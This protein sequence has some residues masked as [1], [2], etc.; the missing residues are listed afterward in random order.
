MVGQDDETEIFFNYE[1]E[2]DIR[3][4]RLVTLAGVYEPERLRR[5]P[6]RI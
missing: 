5:P 1:L 4:T 3:P 6:N 2:I